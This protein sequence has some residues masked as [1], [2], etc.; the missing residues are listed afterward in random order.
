MVGTH[1]CKGEIGINFHFLLAIVMGFAMSAQGSQANFN[2][3]LTLAFSLRNTKR[4]QGSLV[5]LYIKAQV[6]GAF[7]GYVVLYYLNGIIV[8]PI[9][10]I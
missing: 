9:Q 3:A 10:P 7:A 4:Y 6:A 8:D 5:W 1:S 2:P